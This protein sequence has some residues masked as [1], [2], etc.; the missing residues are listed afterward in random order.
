MKK[1][2]GRGP[3]P[4]GESIHRKSSF[5]S[6]CFDIHY[7]W[8]LTYTFACTTKPATKHRS[9]YHCSEEPSPFLP[10]ITQLLY[11]TIRFQKFQAAAQGFVAC[12]KK[13]ASFHKSVSSNYRIT[14]KAMV[15]P[16]K[17]TFR[18]PL[19][20]N[21][22]LQLSLDHKLSQWEKILPRE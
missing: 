19:K 15:L 12:R 16:V 6:T 11:L 10:F 2:N 20:Y 9:L 7:Q 5:W 1:R 17:N 3:L 18:T 13:V 4:M 14:V 22:R 21:T 8:S